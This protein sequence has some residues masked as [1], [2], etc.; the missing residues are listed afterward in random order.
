MG[1]LEIKGP[2]LDLPLDPTHHSPMRGTEVDVLG[3][4]SV[5]MRMNTEKESRRVTPIEIFSPHSD[6]S[7][8]TSATS[9][10]NMLDGRIRFMT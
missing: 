1:T 6:G 9:R 10:D 2:T 5:I 3:T 4:D 7:R 8:K